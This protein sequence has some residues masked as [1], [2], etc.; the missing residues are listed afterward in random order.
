MHFDRSAILNRNFL[1]LLLGRQI[2]LGLIFSRCLFLDAS[3]LPLLEVDKNAGQN[4]KPDKGQNPVH[5]NFLRV[6]TQQR[7]I[8]LLRG[9][10]PLLLLRF[11]HLV[12]H[13]V[14]AAGRLA[15]LVPGVRL[16]A[17]AA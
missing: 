1:A 16:A 9:G 15:E 5:Q 11:E 6:F 14:G 2:I 3:F 13:E 7:L 12:E 17:E 10:G 4:H 8:T